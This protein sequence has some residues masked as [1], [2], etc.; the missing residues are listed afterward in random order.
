MTEILIYNTEN[1]LKRYIEPN[2][3]HCSGQAILDLIPKEIP[4]VGLEIGTDVGETARYLLKMNPHMFLYCVDPYKTYIDWNGNNIN[5]REKIL[6]EFTQRTKEYEN[7][8]MLYRESSNDATIFFENESLDFVFIDGL[9]EFTQTY[10]DC[11]NF[12]PKLKKG[13]LFCGHDYNTI[14]AVKKAVDRFA[15]EISMEVNTAIN[16]V[17]YFYKE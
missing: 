3:F 16:D 4:V 14:P 8:Y 5:D 15:S 12:Y 2:Q 6:E 13:G 11:V 9:H 1:A 7:R 17:W 10:L